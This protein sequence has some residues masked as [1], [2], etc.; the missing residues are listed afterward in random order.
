MGHSVTLFEAKKKL[1]GMLRYGIP[2]Y[3]LPREILD[4]EIADLVS[5][6]ITVKTETPVGDNPSILDLKKE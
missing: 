4:Q 3:R 1:G 2:S 5:A 6:G